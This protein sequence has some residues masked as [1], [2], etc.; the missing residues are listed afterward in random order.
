MDMRYT[1]EELWKSWV[2]KNK[3]FAKSLFSDLANSFLG[4]N[5]KGTEKVL[6]FQCPLEVRIIF[7]VNRSKGPPCAAGGKRCPLRVRNRNTTLVATDRI[8]YNQKPPSCFFPTAR[9]CP[10]PCTIIC[11][12]LC[13]KA[14]YLLSC[15]RPVFSVS[16]SGVRPARCRSYNVRRSEPAASFPPVCPVFRTG[17]QYSGK[18]YDFRAFLGQHGLDHIIRFRGVTR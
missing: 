13:N 5:R 6:I 2:Y 10:F 17:S 7:S 11:L 16:V 3:K 12:P 8:I 4:L 1:Y 18:A 14:V 9:G 15:T